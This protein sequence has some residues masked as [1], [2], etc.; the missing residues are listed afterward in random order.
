MYI[1]LYIMQWYSSDRRKRTGKGMEA[2]DNVCDGD[3]LV[4]HGW[5]RVCDGGERERDETIK[6]NRC[7]MI[8]GLVCKKPVKGF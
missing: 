8:K 4:W 7:Q 5:G 3:E 1:L 2:K 6:M